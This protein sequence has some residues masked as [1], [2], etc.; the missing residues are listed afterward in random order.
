MIN[1]IITTVNVTEISKYELVEIGVYAII[2]LDLEIIRL[3]IPCPEDC[4]NH[5][6]STVFIRLCV[7]KNGAFI[8]NCV[9]SGTKNHI[10]QD[11]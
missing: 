11:A 4:S 9:D 3:F 8:V 5:P 10:I 1:D 7:K 2:V 6:W